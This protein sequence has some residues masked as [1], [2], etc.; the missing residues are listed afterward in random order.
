[1]PAWMW[2]LACAPVVWLALFV[3]LVL[4]ARLWLGS[5]P[6]PGFPD[7]KDLGFDLHLFV[8]VLG[9]PVMMAAAIRVLA[10]AVVAPVRAGERWRLSLTAMAS[11]GFVL[12]LAQADPG[13]IFTWLG[14]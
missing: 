13:W 7:P 2:G 4:R 8:V 14:D 9:V 6:A 1:V 5:W 12:L 3:A 11:L 10:F